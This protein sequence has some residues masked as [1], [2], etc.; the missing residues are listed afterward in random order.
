MKLD[1]SQKLKSRDV[2]IK[3]NIVK[4]LFIKSLLLYTY[5]FIYHA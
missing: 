5:I 4:I 1:E 2:E 3:K